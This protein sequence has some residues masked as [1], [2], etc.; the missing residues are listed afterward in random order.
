MPTVSL[1]TEQFQGLGAATA[2]GR[3]MPRLP[4]IVMPHGYDQWTEEAI[5]EQIRAK[6]PAILAA[7]TAKSA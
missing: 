2:E 4:I 3:K 1:V 7:L 5:R 6:L